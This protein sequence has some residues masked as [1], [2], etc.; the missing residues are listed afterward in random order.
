MSEWSS[1]IN[2]MFFSGV[3]DMTVFSPEIL[4]RLIIFMLML[5]FMGGVFTI[6]GKL[7]KAGKE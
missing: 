1:M 6:L 7:G 2:E 3:E 5:E 4:V